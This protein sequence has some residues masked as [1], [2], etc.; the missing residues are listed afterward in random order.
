V[1]DINNSGSSDPDEMTVMGG[2]LY[3]RARGGAMG[4]ELWTSDGTA[5]GT[6]RVKDIQAGPRGSFPGDLTVAGGLLYFGADDGIHGYELWVSD[7]TEAGTRLVKDIKH[8]AAG[9]FPG[10]LTPVGGELWFFATTGIWVSDGTAQGT[11]L[12]ASLPPDLSLDA[13]PFAFKGRMYFGLDRCGGD[14]CSSEGLWRS[15]G[16]TAGTKQFHFDADDIYPEEI[17]RT[18]SLLY[19][20][21]SE[22][23]NVS[24]GTKASTQRLLS[25]SRATFGLTRL[26]ETMFFGDRDQDDDGGLWI[27]DG[28]VSGTNELAEFWLV[29]SWMTVVGGRV[30]FAATDDELQPQA[31]YR[32]NGTTQSTKA[33]QGCCP[34][35]AEPRFITGAGGIAYFA[36]S[37]RSTCGDGSCDDRELWRSNGTDGGTFL[38]ADIRPGSES[39]TP[40]FLIDVGGA[41]FFTADDGV[42]G[43][44]LWRYVP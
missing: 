42:H 28:S 23:L 29:P 38:V 30:F 43:R 6:H 21:D 9:S 40:M 19:W 31:L 39:S 24:N 34:D 44:E 27:T 26:G 15:N 36:A 7:G 32:S 35:Q 20:T 13:Q 41:L 33:V 14:V 17:S 4:R 1:E 37:D 8:G 18:Q 25:S 16:T 22:G 3:F 5:A 12:I 11:H 10:A 2:K